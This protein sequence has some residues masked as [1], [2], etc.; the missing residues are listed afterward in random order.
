MLQFLK[1]LFCIHAFDYE[2]DISVRA[3]CRNCGKT[4]PD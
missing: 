3:E 2:S 1:R 4:K